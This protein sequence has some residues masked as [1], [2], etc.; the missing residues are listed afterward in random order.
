M[1]LIPLPPESVKSL[2]RPDAEHLDEVED[3]PMTKEQKLIEDSMSIF[4]K[5]MAL[6]QCSQYDRRVQFA[7][8]IKKW[9]N[10]CMKKGVHFDQAN[11][12]AQTMY[13]RGVKDQHEEREQISRQMILELEARNLCIKT[14]CLLNK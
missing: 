5:R 2:D 14:Y 11:A 7:R 3:E 10:D 4:H 9:A 12:E 13:A 1:K 6:F 8:R